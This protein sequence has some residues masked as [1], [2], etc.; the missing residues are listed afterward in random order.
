MNNLTKSIL[1]YTAIVF[2][3]LTT[4]LYVVG[5]LWNEYGVKATK[6]ILSTAPNGSA[7][8]IAMDIK[9]ELLMLDKLDDKNYSA[10]YTG[11]CLKLK[12]LLRN[13]DPTLSDE[14]EHAQHLASLQSKAMSRL[15]H[16]SAA[17]VCGTGS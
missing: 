9:W 3:S 5:L 4:S 17:G 8:D 2:S 1:I 11:H 12:G 13:V 7:G 14:P 15:E 10:L 16:L 6:V